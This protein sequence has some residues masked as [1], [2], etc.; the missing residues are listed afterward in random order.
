MSDMDGLMNGQQQEATAKDDAPSEAQ[1]LAAMELSHT[2]P[3][4]YP[5]VVIGHHGPDFED[6]LRGAIL[7]VQGGEPFTI[8][9]RHSAQGRYIA[10]H[11]ELFVDT[12]RTAL[13]RKTL[14]AE[15]EGVLWML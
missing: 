14:L 3:G 9:E 12:A 5:V 10:Y 4:F 2:F 8:R 7:I 15:V 1:L 13:S 11:V 6:R